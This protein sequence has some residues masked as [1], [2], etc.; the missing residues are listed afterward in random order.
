LKP[1]KQID[2]IEQF[3]EKLLLKQAGENLHIHDVRTST[4][5]E[6]IGTEDLA[7]SAFIFL[8]DKQRFLTIKGRDINLWDFNGNVVTE[9]VAKV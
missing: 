3:S 8:N 1:G 5:L 7:P 6:V 2:F 4:T 9:Y